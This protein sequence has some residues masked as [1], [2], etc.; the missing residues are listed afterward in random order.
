ME[1]WAHRGRSQPI[2]FGNTL[3]DFEMAQCLGITGIETDISFSLDKKII[4]YHPGTTEQDY[5]KLIWETIQTQITKPPVMRLD[6]LLIFLKNNPKLQCCLD[7]KEDSMELVRK[8]LVA[9]I[10]FNLEERV[11]LSAFLKRRPRLKMESDVRLLDHA[12]EI[13]P[14][15]KTHIMV[16]WPLNLVGIVEKHRPDAISFGWLQEPWWIWLISQPLFKSVSLTINLKKQV[17]EVK[18][19]GVKV[20][21]GVVNKPKDMLYFADLGVDGIVTDNP[22]LLMDLIKQNKIS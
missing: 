4:I 6:D 7:I 14:R 21:A 5:T 19:K 11:Y 9:I 3:S 10:S 20:W 18:R 15:I 2:H 17:G 16:P 22:R 12:K 8:A 1:I 13:C